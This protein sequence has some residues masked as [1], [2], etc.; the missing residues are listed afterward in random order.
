MENIH[1]FLTNVYC[2]QEWW[3]FN[4]IFFK[5]LLVCLPKTNIYILKINYCRLVFFSTEED[6]EGLEQ[7]TISVNKLYLKVNVNNWDFR[8]LIV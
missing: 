8:N 6:E 4:L 2:L 7:S 5:C 1:V 3:Y